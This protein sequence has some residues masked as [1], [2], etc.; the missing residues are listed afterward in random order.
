MKIKASFLLAITF[1]VFWGCSANVK[2]QGYITIGAL[3]PLTGPA[4]DEGL[5]TLNGIHL[6]KEEINARG[7]VL[8]KKL[9]II[10]LND[11]GD[12]EYIV[13]QYN[14]LMENNIAAIIGS[15]YSGPTLVLARESEKDGIPVISPTAS[16]PAVTL[17]RSN[18]FRSIFI[19]DYQ[20][21]IMAQF[22]YD[23]LG[24]RTALV[25]SNINY[26]TYIQAAGVFAESFTA[27]GGHVMAIE[28]F[29]S[30]DDFAS[31]LG[32]YADNQPQVIFCPE[33]YIPAAVLINNAFE[34]GFRDTFLLGS[35]AWDGILTYVFNQE[36]MITAYYSAPFSFDDPDEKVINFVRG[37]FDFFAQKP[38]AGPATAYTSLYILA[39]AIEK[40]GNTNW[41]DIIYAM[42][43]MEFDTIL[44]HLKFDENNNPY[45][46][47]Y[48]IQIKDGQYSSYEKLSLKG[49][50]ELN[51][52]P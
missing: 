49:Q 36:A 2:E 13:E 18:V 33:D 10:V 27:L 7:G 39:E 35:D 40:A 43:T 44:G 42:K 23:S 1:I 28:S 32:K 52:E 22:A 37:Y 48:V 41:G 3:L 12:T 14:K 25:L 20:A 26:D 21:E 34:L 51:K 30:E 38:L 11:R 8:G 5:R 46:N 16:N 19:D 15:S 29:S 4:S 9:D 24:A 47:V 31:L 6:A 17:G 45:I 50:R